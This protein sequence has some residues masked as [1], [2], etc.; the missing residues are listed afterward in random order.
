MPIQLRKNLQRKRK[1]QNPHKNSRMFYL[2]YF[3]ILLQ[4]GEKPFKCSVENCDKAFIS[5]GKLNSH[6]NQHYG[7]KPYSCT[8]PG[9]EKKYNGLSRLTIH[10]RT[11]TGVKPFTCPN[12]GK[13]FNEKGNMK[14][15]IRI[16]TG[17]KPYVCTF[18]GCGKRFKAKG[19][20]TDH[21]KIHSKLKPFECSV[22][23]SRFSRSST[24]KIHTQ[25]H[26]EK[27]KNK[28]D[29]KVE[30]KPVEKDST[31][32][33]KENPNS[34]KDVNNILNSKNNQISEPS[35]IQS[36][37]TNFAESNSHYCINNNN[38]YSIPYVT[39]NYFLL[40]FNPY[41]FSAGV[42]DTRN[43]YQMMVN[44]SS[45]FQLQKNF[46]NQLLVEEQILLL[47]G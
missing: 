44:P 21:T 25:L 34:T 24:L 12:C 39:N 9:C 4:T 7:I 10:L 3:L 1:P 30:K 2:Y 26:C 6:L 31:T 35:Q 14:T 15:H 42:I 5:K 33:A 41:W 45:N 18:P 27:K 23:H 47:L 40:G 29:S 37:F 11:H 43:N 38:Y 16:H 13:S 22:C 17:E 32:E 46:R 36:S 28:K 19:H 8:Y 20:L